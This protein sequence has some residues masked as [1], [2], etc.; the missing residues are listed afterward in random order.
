M[1]ERNPDEEIREQEELAQ[2]AKQTDPAQGFQIHEPTEDELDEDDGYVAG[3]DRNPEP[4]DLEGT[5][6][7]PVLAEEEGLEKDEVAQDEVA[8]GEL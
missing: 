3:D 8:E 4:H 6:D 2:V 1:E 7:E 5:V